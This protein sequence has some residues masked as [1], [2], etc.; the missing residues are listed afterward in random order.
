MSTRTAIILVIVFAAAIAIALAVRSIRRAPVLEAGQTYTVC[1][2]KSHE[3]ADSHGTKYS[4]PHLQQGDRI[5]IV[6]VNPG[7]VQV[8]EFGEVPMQVSADGTWATATLQAS[9]GGVTA[10]G[11]VQD[12]SLD[13]LVYVVSR[14]SRPAACKGGTRYIRIAFCAPADAT[15]SPGAWRCGTAN[16]ATTDHL[17]DVHA[18]N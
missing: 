15:A 14:T 17:G 2:E 12:A 13:H 6:G 1:E 9:H 3:H 8:A 10:A 7:K 11:A 18:E 4:T 5:T 16:P